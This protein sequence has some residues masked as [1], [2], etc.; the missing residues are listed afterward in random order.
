MNKNFFV[1]FFMMICLCWITFTLQ[2]VYA[3]E[4]CYNLRVSPP[5][6]WTIDEFIGEH[7]FTDNFISGQK[8]ILLTQPNFIVVVP[9]YG[10]TAILV[11]SSLNKQ[12]SI[13][14]KVHQDICYFKAGKIDV[15]ITEKSPSNL[16]VNY[17]SQRG[18]FKQRKPGHLSFCIERECSE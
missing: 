4:G 5:A 18:S 13:T 16:T 12:Q 1:N 11:M 17:V 7:G 6:G 14:A 3:S 8:D 9:T 15:E 2:S 10:I